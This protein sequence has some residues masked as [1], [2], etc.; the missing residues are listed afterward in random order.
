M[1]PLHA[2]E[3]PQIDYP[4]QWEYRLIGF[5]EDLLRGA[6]DEVMGQLGHIVS[7]SNRSRSGKFVSLS[8]ELRVEDESTR[9]GLFDQFQN[10]PD[11]MMVL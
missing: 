5:N 1:D 7:F 2:D 8:V 4:C 6:I 11:V 10:H 9:L 3:H